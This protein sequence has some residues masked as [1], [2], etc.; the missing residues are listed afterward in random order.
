MKNLEERTKVSLLKMLKNYEPE[1]EE[2]QLEKKDLTELLIEALILPVVIRQSEQFT[3]KTC[4]AH[5]KVWS[6]N[7]DDWYCKTCGHICK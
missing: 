4:G 6:S 5:E 7:N 1:N 2:Q 3:C